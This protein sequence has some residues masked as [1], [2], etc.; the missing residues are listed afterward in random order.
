MQWLG[1]LPN[2]EEWVRNH[3]MLDHASWTDP[4][5]LSSTEL[6]S[7]LLHTHHCVDGPPPSQQNDVAQPPTGLRIHIRSPFRPY[8]HLRVRKILLQT[9]M[10]MSSCLRFT[11]PYLH[12]LLP[13]VQ[14]ISRLGWRSV[15]REGEGKVQ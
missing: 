15:G 2:K 6:H 4:D 1:S 12:G 3:D 7:T 14:P 13:V 9:T 5:L 11:L 10:L 8:T